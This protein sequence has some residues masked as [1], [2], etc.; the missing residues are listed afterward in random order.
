MS[1]FGL[2]NEF[3]REHGWKNHYDAK[4]QILGSV[5]IKEDAVLDFD[6]LP[7]WKAFD[8]YWSPNFPHLKIPKPSR[9]ICGECYVYANKIRFKQQS[10]PGSSKRSLASLLQEDSDNDDTFFVPPEQE[11]EDHDAE[12]ERMIESE[13]IIKK[14]SIQVKRAKAQR[15][16]F[17]KRRKQDPPS[18]CR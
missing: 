9:D 3:L 16:L 1:R 11:D 12:Q 4:N 13:D 5:K 7:S 2:F 15:D 18:T 6:E 17:N 10:N 8:L 14:A